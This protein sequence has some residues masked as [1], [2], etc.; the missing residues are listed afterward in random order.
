[1]A[2]CRPLAAPPTRAT[3]PRIAIIASERG[4][5]GARLVSI[6]EHGD[7]QLVLA[8]AP[9]AIAR[10]TH[11]SISP[12]GTRIVFASSRNRPLDETSLWLAPLGD[13]VEPQRLTT[14]SAIDSHPTWT[15][16]GAAIVFASTRGG[17]GFELWRL[18]LATR[19]LEQ[20]T[21]SGGHAITPTIARDGS[22]IYAKVTQLGSGSI[23][24]HLELRSPDGTISRITDGPADGAPALSPD[25]TVIAFARPVV[26]GEAADSD[27]WRMPRSGGGATQIVD[28]PLADESGPVWSPDGRYIFATSVLRNAAGA[29]VFSSIIHVDLRGPTAVARIL[30]DRAGAIARL[31]PAVARVPLDTDALASDPE[32]LPE[33]GR[34]MAKAIAEQQ[35]GPK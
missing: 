12:D 9:D 5:R 8:R 3:S 6:D 14:G 31:T 21:T 10:E 23:E 26:R 29:A 11:P 2:A 28:V 32:Y 15:R 33:L 7:R 24:S 13:E 25:D 16:D 18:T 34:I 17:G 1:M 19:V 27:L 35:A 4:P 30:E 22:I 20:L